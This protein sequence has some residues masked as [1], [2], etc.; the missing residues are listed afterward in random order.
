MR[1]QTVSG[2]VASDTGGVSVA[3]AAAVSCKG[4]LPGAGQAVLQHAVD[5]PG[6]NEAPLAGSARGVLEEGS[7]HLRGEL[8]GS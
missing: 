5:D 6:V 8:P 7:G 2:G 1:G 4:F 3:L